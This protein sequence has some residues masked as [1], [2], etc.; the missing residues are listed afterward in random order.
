MHYRL[1]KL[2]FLLFFSI[3]IVGAPLLVLYTA[4][5]RL[6]LTNL[7]VQQTGVIAISSTPRGASVFLDGVDTGAKTPY[8]LQRLSPGNYTVTLVRDGYRP[9]EQRVDVRS[10]E[11]TYITTTLFAD[12]QPELLFETIAIDVTGDQSGRFVDLLL[13]F[14]EKTGT[15]MVLRYDTVTHVSRVLATLDRGMTATYQTLRLSTD[16]SVLVLENETETVGIN[17]AT[18]DMLEGDTLDAATDPLPGYTFTDN[19]TNTE[20][21]TSDTNSLITLL[22]PGTYSVTFANDTHAMFVDARGRTYF[23]T[24]ATETVSHIAFP[25][26]LVD[27]NS[28]G[29]LFVGSDGNE[30]DVFDPASGSITLLTRQSEAIIGLSWH[31]DNQS[32][33]CATASSIF[34]VAR[35]NHETREITTLVEGA[36]IVGMWPDTT[37]KHLTFFGTVDGKTGIWSLA[38]TQ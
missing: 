16:E 30:I 18:G 20:F 3:F 8:V 31:T 38:L 22:P 4:G 33:L 23:Y 11:T 17:V 2:I 24:F 29:T 14:D 9:W 25:S 27:E 19:G 10:G 34:A 32:V 35:E 1:R 15:Q 28:D 26:T 12:A 13:P 7:R 6:N 37:G 36:S 5:Y 21:R